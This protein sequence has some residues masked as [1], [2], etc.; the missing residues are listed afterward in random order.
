MTLNTEQKAALDAAVAGDSLFITGPGGVGKTYLVNHIVET[1]TQKGKRVAITALTGCAALLLGSSAKTIHS[2]AGIGLGRDSASAIV[3]GIQKYNFPAKKR[4]ICTDTLIIDEV[5]MLTP[6]LL[7]KLND[8]AI[9]LRR[10]LRPFGGLQVLFV[11]DFYQLPPVYIDSEDPGLKPSKLFAFESD[12]W[13]SLELKTAYL[14]QI[15]RQTDPIFHKL[16]MEARAGALTDKSLQLLLNRKDQPWE[17]LKIKPTLLFSRRAEVDMINEMNLRSIEAPPKF[18]EVKTVF[19]VEFPKG[20]DK[21]DQRVVRA[22]TKLDR[23]APYKAKLELKPGAQVMLIYNLDTEKGLVNGSRGVVEGFTE[24]IPPQPL[25]LFQGSHQAI[26]VGTQSWPSEDIDGLKRSQIPLILAYA[27]TI[28][29]SQG[30]TLDSALIDIGVSTF[31]VGQAYVALSRV[32]SLDSL[33]VYDLDPNAFKA[34][35]KVKDFYDSL[36]PPDK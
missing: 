18:F 32:K 35:P 6:E 30:A 26:P 8:V 27:V 1:L 2:W 21:T 33:F 31:E 12:V 28:H 9:A 19:D 22:L 4:W 23:S 15:V 10:K 29:K 34:H 11:G 16:L 20:T 36:T 14:K 25:V 3:A 17:H 13:R 5:S 7:E 24:T